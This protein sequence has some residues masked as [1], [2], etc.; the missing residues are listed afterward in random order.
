[1]TPEQIVTSLKCHQSILQEL[2]SN[3]EKLCIFVQKSHETWAEIGTEIELMQLRLRS[4]EHD[5]D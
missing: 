2:L 3:Q 5:K 1:M 4:L